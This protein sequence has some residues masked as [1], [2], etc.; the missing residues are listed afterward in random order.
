MIGLSDQR[1]RRLRADLAV[2]L[3]R[4]GYSLVASTVATSILGV[5][6]WGIAARHA[7]AAELRSL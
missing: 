1:S 5:L 4:N 7:S 2:P 6:F 3:F